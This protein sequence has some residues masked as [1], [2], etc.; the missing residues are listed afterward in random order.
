[1]HNLDLKWKCRTVALSG[2]ALLLTATGALAQGHGGGGRGPA[3]SG[4]Q[5]SPG[6]NY[7]A[8]GLA[9]VR[10]PSSGYAYGYG[11]SSYG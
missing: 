7:H 8:S 11:S 9:P 3:L 4:A 6:A 1:M 10:I 5:L 2:A